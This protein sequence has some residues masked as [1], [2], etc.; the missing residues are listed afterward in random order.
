MTVVWLV[1]AAILFWL[2]FVLD[3]SDVD[4]IDGV[5]RILFTLVPIKAFAWVMSIVFLGIG[6]ATARGAL[7]ADSNRPDHSLES[8]RA[9]ALD[10]DA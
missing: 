8:G 1:G 7:R 9:E 6:A 3:P 10:G 4:A 5:Q 2:G